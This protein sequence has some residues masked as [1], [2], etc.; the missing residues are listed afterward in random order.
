MMRQSPIHSRYPQARGVFRDFVHR[1]DMDRTQRAC[2]F[3]T[4]DDAY[5]PASQRTVIVME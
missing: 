1:P 5:D 3:G 4:V 2:E